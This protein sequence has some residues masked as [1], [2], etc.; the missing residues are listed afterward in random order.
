MKILPLSLVAMARSMD[1]DDI[2]T[3]VSELEADSMYLKRFINNII[4]NKNL[5][6][7]KNNFQPLI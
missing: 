2:D 5:K 1:I 4:L 7:I 6:N 3:V